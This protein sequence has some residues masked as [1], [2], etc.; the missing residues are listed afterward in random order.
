[1][2]SWPDD[3]D[4]LFDPAETEPA[5]DLGAVARAFW[6]LP[7]VLR[8]DH[9]QA[10][11]AR[12]PAAGRVLA[13][14]LP[15]PPHIAE[16]PIGRVHDVDGQV[17][18]LGVNHDANTTIH[19]AELLAGVPYRLPKICSALVDGEVVRIEYG[20]NDHCCEGFRLADGWLSDAGTQTVGRVGHATAR[21]CRS[22][23]IVSV[24]VPR[25]EADPL[26]F[27]CDASASCTE[28]D[29]ARRSTVSP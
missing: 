16:S 21:L 27:L 1:M 6:R 3:A 12:G 5:L 9:V 15:L 2:P 24:V 17:L 19:L 26:L 25:L 4:P 14:P 11:A 8:T 13:D 28:C 18:L 23:D 7:G 29:E 20:E 10:F 22:R